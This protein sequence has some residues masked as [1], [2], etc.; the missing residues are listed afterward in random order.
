MLRN[1]LKVA[2]R[3]LLKY[4]TFSFINVFGLAVSM[5]LCLIVI[6]LVVD[7]LSYDNH[8]TNKERIYRVNTIPKVQGGR[9]ADYS[10]TASTTM[11]LRNVL[12]EDYTGVEKAVRL[13]RGFGNPSWID[14]GN[15]VNIPVTGFYAD[16]E[17]LDIFQLELEYGNPATALTDP[18]SVVLTKAAADKLFTH[19]NPV[20]ELLKVGKQGDFKITGVLK[21]HPEH[22]SHIVFDG[23]AS[24]STLASKAAA[25]STYNNPLE[26]W[27][28]IYDGYVYLLLEKGNTK[29][30]IG[31]KLAKIAEAKYAEDEMT[32]HAFELQSIT[33]ITPGPLLN[34]PI[35]PFLPNIFVYFLGGLALIVMITSCFN[36][37]NL[38]VARSLTRAKEI[39]IRK[40][41]G[42]M[43]YQ[44]FMQFLSEAVIIA[45]L[46]L[47]LSW[48]IVIISKPVLLNLSMVQL[49]RW[50]FS[51][52]TE[53]YPY[54]VGFTVV[55]GLLAGLFPAA[56]LSSFQPIKVLKNFGSMK[57]LS[58][59]GLRKT[60]LVIQ[61]ALSLIFILSA[62]MVYKQTELFF[63]TDHGFSTTD[64]IV[65]R[66]NNSSY[67]LLKSELAQYNNIVNVSG[68]SHTPAAGYIYADVFKLSPDD[69]GNDMDYFYVDADYLANMDIELIAGQNFNT[70][71]PETNKRKII[72]SSLTVEKFG[73]ES[74]DEALGQVLYADK[75]SIGYTVIGVVP[76]YLHRQLISQNAPMGLIYKSDGFNQL[77]VRFTGSK[78]AIVETIKT[79]WAKVNPELKVDYKFFDDEMHEIYNVLFG[80]LIK[81]VGFVAFLAITISCLGLLGMATYAA[82]TRIKEVAIRKTL[83][84]SVA[85]IAMMLSKGFLKLVAVAVCIGLP[86]SWFINNLWLESMAHR[87]NMGPGVMLFGL[88]VL[89]LLTVVTV[90][91]QSL[92]AAFANPASNLRND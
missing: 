37:T 24:A 17:V 91:S 31:Q 40:V 87:V 6:M 26:S 28:K 56:V 44:I 39:G 54:I 16:P 46:A 79:A 38:S 22:K 81:V 2:L 76:A 43:R 53:V 62:T 34:N 3:S 70:T 84:A 19:A 74:P 30:D 5:S 50:D 1:Y 55:V 68:A 41:A 21:H 49:F 78:E 27:T 8:N 85:G 80:D 23:L 11:A 83:G 15:D 48:L 89:A 10:K 67:D 65:V 73:F 36:Y 9:K 32:E 42:A 58:R 72:I 20:G 14:F 90:G 12:L 60:L 33:A 4:R 29:E 71:S 35:G 86:A 25:D 63:T 66:L 75:D 77:Q 51:T 64:K 69:E 18:Y 57:L 59:V 52:S 82:E 61:F 7:Q 88:F 13:M 47:G 45:F 92:R